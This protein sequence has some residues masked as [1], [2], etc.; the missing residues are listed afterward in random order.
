MKKC[1]TLKSFFFG[2]GR[3]LQAVNSIFGNWA[4][5][6]VF[7][8]IFSHNGDPG[9]TAPAGRFTC[10]FGILKAQLSER[11]MSHSHSVTNWIASLKAH[12][13]QDAA[14]KLWERYWQRLVGLAAKKITRSKRQV[15][16][17]EDVAQIAMKS[18]FIGARE[19]RFPQLRDRHDLWPL[20]VRITANKAMD[21]R[22]RENAQKRGGQQV[23]HSLQRPESGGATHEVEEVL[24][25]QPSPDFSLQL[26]EEYQRLLAALP[27]VTMRQIAVW[28]MERYTQ[29]EIAEKLGCVRRTVQR[30]LQLIQRIWTE[31]SLTE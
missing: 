23:I 30:R 16:D 7:A 29:D 27:D 9:S 10:N 5:L 17:E 11:G 14:Q 6:P 21:K 4:F 25:E 31:E 26:T 24:D 8:S 28:K 20:L 15:A 1:D 22:T 12:D 18:F 13:D 2:G 19:G 3:H